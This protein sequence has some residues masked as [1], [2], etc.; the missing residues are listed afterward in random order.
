[1]ASAS[2]REKVLEGRGRGLAFSAF[3]RSAVNSVAEVMGAGVGRRFSRCWKA[4]LKLEGR[5]VGGVLLVSRAESRMAENSSP[6]VVARWLGVGESGA[7]CCLL[8]VVD[9]V[10]DEVGVASRCCRP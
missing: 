6:V 3:Q 1:M 9:S 5:G 2:I 7:G 4:D 10:L 8:Q